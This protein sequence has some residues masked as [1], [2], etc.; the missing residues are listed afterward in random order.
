LSLHTTFIYKHVLHSPT[1]SDDTCRGKSSEAAM[2]RHAMA[3]NFTQKEFQK[4]INFYP[5]NKILI[6]WMHT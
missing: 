3:E 2:S 4:K 5:K 1:A 6:N